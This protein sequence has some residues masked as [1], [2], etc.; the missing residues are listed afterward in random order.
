[1]RVDRVSPW[2]SALYRPKLEK[3]R[4]EKSRSVKEAEESATPH[5]IQAMAPKD[6][7]EEDDEPPHERTDILV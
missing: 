1:M 3:L 4:Q 5:A 2:Q 6:E 7:G